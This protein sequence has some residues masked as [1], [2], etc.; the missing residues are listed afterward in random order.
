MVSICANS[1]QRPDWRFSGIPCLTGDEIIPSD[2]SSNLAWHQNQ[3]PGI[4]VK[5]TNSARHSFCVK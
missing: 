4:T 1:R 2:S 3:Y 5:Q